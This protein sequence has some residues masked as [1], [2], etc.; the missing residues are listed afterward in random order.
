MT[1][2]IIDNI[3]TSADEVGILNHT[4]YKYL[5]ICMQYSELLSKKMTEEKIEMKLSKEFRMKPESIHDVYHRK[6]KLI[7][8]PKIIK[9]FSLDESIESAPRKH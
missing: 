2:K 3:A 6:A 9:F 4:A 5:Q 7:F 8:N 1:K